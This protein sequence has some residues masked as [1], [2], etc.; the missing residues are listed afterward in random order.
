MSRGGSHSPSKERTNDGNTEGDIPRMGWWA[1]CALA[2]RRIL[3]LVLFR[4]TGSHDNKKPT[5]FLSV[6]IIVFKLPTDSAPLNPCPQDNGSHHCLWHTTRCR[7]LSSLSRG[8]K[9]LPQLY[10][11]PPGWKLP[12]LSPVAASSSAY[13]T[14][15][16]KHPAT[17]DTHLHLASPPALLISEDT[18]T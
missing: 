5:D 3:S 11:P 16:M 2:E 10:L 6:F 12:N 15:P 7:T 14:F 17:S 18:P 4:V 1:L 9:Q 13:R 8:A